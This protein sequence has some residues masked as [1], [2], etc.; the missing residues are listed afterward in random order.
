MEEESP[1]AQVIRQIARNLAAQVSIRNLV[2]P[3]TPKVEIIL[4]NQN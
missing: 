2:A 4:G 1:Q 3:Q